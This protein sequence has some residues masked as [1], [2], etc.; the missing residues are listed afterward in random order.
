MKRKST[1]SLLAAFVALLT[2]A[3]GC[4]SSSKSGTGSTGSGGTTA[5]TA[6][7]V[8]GDAEFV[9]LGGWQD[10]ACSASKPKV[11]VGISAPVDVA[12]TSL[13]DYVD[14]TQA[15]VTAFNA[16]GGIN[17]GC[18]DLKVCDG[19]G[20]GPTELSCAR[21]ETEDTTM[22]AGLASTFEASEGDAYQL[23]QSAGLAQIGAQVT[24]PGAWNS[25]V[26]YEFTMG[27]SGTL[28]AGMPALKNVG[29]S[30]FVIFVPASGQIG[31]LAAFANPLVKALGMNLAETIQ[32]PPTAVEFTQF[33][34][35]AQNKG[36][37]GGVLG[38][39]GNVGGQVIE[40][41]DSLGSDLKLSSSWGTFSQKGVTQLPDS[42]SKNMAFTDAVPPAVANSPRWPIFNVIID[43]FKPSGK[44]DL[45]A[46]SIT[47]EAT[48]GWL[49]V[50]SLIKV[51]RDAKATVIT[52]ATV[53]KAF[54]QAKNIPMFGL[55]PPWT[56][57][58]QSTNSVFKGISNPMY[59]TGHWDSDKKQFVVDDKQVDILALLG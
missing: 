48:N 59:W 8:T 34:L 56:P 10:P 58:K 24:Q 17:G 4:S 3:A 18:L 28:L 32:I 25:P 36:A 14:G 38:L 2:L 39:P 45:A 44:A 22:V 30:K 43:D 46:D 33:V 53:Q 5:S 50:Y 26:S 42:I 19:K 20:D 57:S 40:A 52:R 9:K 1:F 6:P 13:A 55:V 27:G 37:D 16:R 21:Q 7:P 54:D 47:A 11:V 51:M 15:A 31:A 12:G 41:A 23:F 49:S 35:A 29:V